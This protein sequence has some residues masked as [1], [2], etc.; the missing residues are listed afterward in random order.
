MPLPIIGNRY[1]LR[2]LNALQAFEA[3]GRLGSVTAAAQALGV[4]SGAISQQIRKLESYVGVALLERSGGQMSLTRWGRIYHQD[5][6]KGMRAL[7]NALPHLNRARNESELTISALTSVINKWLGREIFDWQAKYPDAIV[8]LV[9]TDREP[10]LAEDDVDFRIFYGT[11]SKFENYAELF[12]DWV[13]PACSPS[14]I[15]G[16]RLESVSDVLRFP[17]LNIVWASAFTPAPSWAVWAGSIG[18]VFQE[19]EKGLSHTLSS[20]AIDA[21][22]AGRGFVLAQVSFIG[23]ELKSGRLIIPFDRRVRLSDSYQLAWSPS[24]LQKPFAKEF[25][26]W[27]ISA[28]RRQEILSNPNG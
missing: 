24:S 6:A 19:K 13:V 10:D 18:T 27:L 23:E 16:H 26:R 22:A 14:L 9:G 11:N 12:T 5:V 1:L 28:G 4:S 20:S 3:V 25:H 17:L 7:E 21:A 8:N 15:A 2:H